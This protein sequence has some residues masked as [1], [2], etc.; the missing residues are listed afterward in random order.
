MTAYP[1]IE[2]FD[3]Y[4]IKNREYSQCKLLNCFFDLNCEK[5]YNN[6]HDY[7]HVQIGLSTNK[8][9]V[10]SLIN[11]F[12]NE[13]LI[14][15]ISSSVQKTDKLPVY[16]TKLRRSIKRFDKKHHV[17][18]GEYDITTDKTEKNKRA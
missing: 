11:F 14:V 15:I 12:Q 2:N 9:V 4:R 17:V 18:F 3:D 8:K 16:L 10:N 1:K 5:T 6:L 7:L 13:G